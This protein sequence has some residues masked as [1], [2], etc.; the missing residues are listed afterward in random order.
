MD[1]D[2]AALERAD[3]EGLVKEVKDAIV[4]FKKF[5]DDV[6][7]GW[8]NIDNYVLGH[9]RFSPFIKPSA[10]L[11]RYTRD[12]TRRNRQVQ[13]GYC[14]LHRQRHPSRYRDSVRRVHSFNVSQPQ[15]PPHFDY[16]GRISSVP[17]VFLMHSSQV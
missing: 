1:A 8:A 10:G 4:A 9:V 6:K 7:K 11:N 15:E 12:Y 13:D 2:E 17:R 16:S 14:Q 3:A 5:Y